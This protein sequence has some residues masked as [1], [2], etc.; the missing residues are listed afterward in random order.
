M[1]RRCPP[2]SIEN[3]KLRK[4]DP[5]AEPRQTSTERCWRGNPKSLHKE[6][7]VEFFTYEHDS[8]EEHY[9]TPLWISGTKEFRT[10]ASPMISDA[11]GGFAAIRIWG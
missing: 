4:R 7:V 11:M 1:G 3:G 5:I 8:V 10:L 2:T 9:D 6:P